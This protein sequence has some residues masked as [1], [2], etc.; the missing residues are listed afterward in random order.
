MVAGVHVCITK[1]MCCAGL[2]GLHNVNLL[3]SE[4]RRLAACVPIVDDSLFPRTLSDHA[5]GDEAMSSSL[6]VGQEVGSLHRC[7]TEAVCGVLHGLLQEEG[8]IFARF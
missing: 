3:A 7:S 6:N 5:S 8:I 1:L 4:E 2:K